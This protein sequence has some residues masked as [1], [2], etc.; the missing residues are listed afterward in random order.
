MKIGLIDV[1]GHHYP[2][3]PLMKISA[4]HKARGDS[5]EWYDTMFS[6]RMDKV[7]VSKIFSFSPDYD[8]YIAADEVVYGGSGYCI[9]LVDGKEEYD[10]VKDIPLPP[11]M[12]HIMPDYSLYGI[13]D[14]AYGFLTRGCPNNCGFCHVCAKEGRVSCK[15][16]DLSEWWNGQKDI[17]LCD[18][19]LLACRE[20]M[21]LIR[22]LADSGAYVD[23]NQGLDAKLLTPANIEEIKKIRI[24]EIHFAWD[25]MKNSRRIIKGLN[26]WKRYGK[27]DK[28]GAWGNASLNEYLMPRKDYQPIMFKSDDDVFDT[29]ERYLPAKEFAALPESDAECRKIYD[30]LPWVKAIIVY[31]ELPEPPKED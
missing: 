14:T 8:R 2:N 17:V 4:W 29:L 6:G 19:N 1:D 5:V 3:L 26:L 27:K 22:Q 21:D 18:P 12:E 25:L 23:I 13:T 20:H 10:S 7:Y 16:A 9:S 28:H 24:K 31:I 11:E 15:V 30:S